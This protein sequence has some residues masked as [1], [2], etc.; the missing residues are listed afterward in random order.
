MI[1]IG[2][3]ND[4]STIIKDAQEFF[5]HWFPQSDEDHKMEIK[6]FFDAGAPEFWKWGELAGSLAQVHDLVAPLDAEKAGRYLQRLGVIANALLDNRDDVRGSPIDPFRG[7]VMVAWGSITTDRDCQWNTDPVTAGL[8]V[9]AMTA[10][11]RRVVE[12]PARYAQYS[13]DAIRFITAALETYESF[14]SELHLSDDDKEAYYISPPKYAGLRCAGECY[15]RQPES[16]RDDLRDSCD[17]YR[18][19]AGKPIAFNENLSMMKALADAAVAADS[20]MY[21]NSDHATPER[22]RVA[23]E[24]IPLVIAKNVAFFINH[25][26]AKT[27]SDDTPYFEWSHQVTGHRP[28]DL[29]HAGFELDCLPPI[30]EDQVRLDALLARSGRPERIPLSPAVC[31]GLANTFLRKVWHSNNTL[32]DRVDGV[33]TNEDAGGAGW[34]PLAQFD[35]WVWTRARDTTFKDPDRRLRA[36]THAEL[37]RYREYNLMKHLTEYGGQNWLI[38]PASLAVGETKPQSIHDQKWLLFLSGVVIADLKGDG[39]EWDHQTVA[40]SPDMAG[41]DDP[42]ATSGP[43][44]W[45]IRQYSIPRPPGAAGTQYLVRFQVEGWSPCVSLGA[46]FNKGQSNNS[47]F[48]VDTWRPSHFGTGKNILTD[49]QVNNLF[50]GI[51]ADVAVRDVDAWLY[52]LSYN[53]SLLGKIVFVAPAF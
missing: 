22:L 11:A 16:K 24:E 7:R 13:A 33:G 31:K 3:Q 12:H 23:T 30:L 32:S 28:Q 1:Y 51:T 39:Q 43:L 46:I 36:A 47:G 9:Y 44:N 29:D 41:P 18:D 21:R 10:F 4:P 6:G 19:G 15:D 5:D 48:A 50:S 53:I 14:R 45:A 17:D 35:P 52:R 26:R 25:L 38:T 34:I 42:S 37:L 20:A 49:A 40:F 8:F 2:D 27:L